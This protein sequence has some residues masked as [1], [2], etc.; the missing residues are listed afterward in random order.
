MDMT[1]DIFAD[2]P[3]GKLALQ[4]MK[5][6][7]PDFRLYKAGWLGKG[8]PLRREVM[9]VTGAVF[10]RPLRGPNRGQLSIMVPGTSRTVFVTALEMT[11][12]KQA[13][14]AE[15]EAPPQSGEK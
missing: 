6:T 15:T 2:L 4:K 9:E 12:S 10:R 1:H 13:E 8:Y 14:I 11:A 7:D 3:F 5:P